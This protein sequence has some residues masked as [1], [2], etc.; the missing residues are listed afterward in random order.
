VDYGEVLNAWSCTLLRMNNDMHV[1]GRDGIR[2]AD[3]QMNIGVTQGS[4]CW[5][6]AVSEYQMKAF[7][8]AQ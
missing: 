2:V 7:H 3:R 5:T 4:H 8:K 6:E 1:L